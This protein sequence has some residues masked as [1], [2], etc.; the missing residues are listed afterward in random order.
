[1]NAVILM[2]GLG[3]SELL[4]IISV[5]IL[6]IGGILYGIYRFMYYKAHYSVKKDT[7]ANDYAFC[8]KCGERNSKTNQYCAKCGNKMS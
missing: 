5:F 2:Y 8:T 4:V 7:V 6:T 1:M 3:A